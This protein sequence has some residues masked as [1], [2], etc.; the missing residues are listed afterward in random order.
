M[1]WGVVPQTEQMW[2]SWGSFFP[3]LIKWKV[4]I[5]SGRSHNSCLTLLVSVISH[6]SCWMW[7][8]WFLHRN[9][10]MSNFTK[11]TAS[12]P[13]FSSRKWQKQKLFLWLIDCSQ[14]LSK[15]WRMQSNVSG[16][17][18]SGWFYKLLNRILQ[19]L[20]N[21]RGAQESISRHLDILYFTFSISFH[22]RA[23]T[24]RQPRNFLKDW[25]CTLLG[26]LQPKQHTYSQHNY[27][28]KI[29]GLLW[30]TMS[31]LLLSS[32]T[33]TQTVIHVY[34]LTFNTVNQE[35]C[36]SHIKQGLAAGTLEMIMHEFIL[37]LPLDVWCFLKHKSLLAPVVFSDYT[38]CYS[39]LTPGLC[40]LPFCK[41]LRPV[42]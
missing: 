5:L 35:N 2:H 19:Y 25:K 8:S 34:F 4:F 42:S 20:L 12:V 18:C 31:A 22:I 16:Q 38:F 39:I 37:A 15:L 11:T 27:P 10:N 24:E 21:K 7:K 41:W 36:F 26:I 28:A 14:R 33:Y 13:V 1:H 32:F 6:I 23:A 40:F 3:P 17:N 30:S 9:N 29:S